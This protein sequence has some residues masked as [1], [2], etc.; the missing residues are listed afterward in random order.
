MVVHIEFH[1]RHQALEDLAIDVAEAQLRLFRRERLP[2]VSQVWD[3]YGRD[4]DPVL[5][6]RETLL[7]PMEPCSRLVYRR[8]NLRGWAGRTF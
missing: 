6:E 1:R 2:V 4:D 8:V 3:L 5:S 7:G